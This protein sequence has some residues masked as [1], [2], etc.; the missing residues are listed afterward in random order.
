[1][2]TLGQ[3]FSL[4]YMLYAIDGVSFDPDL[5]ERLASEQDP[6]A[7]KSL[8]RAT[9]Y[10]MTPASMAALKAF[11]ERPGVDPALAS[12][13][14]ELRSSF[15]GLSFSFSNPETL[16]NER[17]KMM[18]R[19]ISDEA[20]IEFDSYTMKLLAKLWRQAC[21]CKR[22]KQQ[23]P[24]RSTHVAGVPPARQPGAGVWGVSAAIVV[25][26]ISD[27]YPFVVYPLISLLTEGRLRWRCRPEARCARL[28][29]ATA[30]HDDAREPMG[31]QRAR[32]A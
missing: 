2:L 32:D 30:L 4:I 15:S 21:M 23:K 18:Q 29:P 26:L 10:L 12:H 17:R 27:F 11:A 24:A 8:L 1:M 19:P 25:A 14:N 13:A 6:V 20:L 16:R 28:H 5:L 3:N 22:K 31:R 9:W 7:Q